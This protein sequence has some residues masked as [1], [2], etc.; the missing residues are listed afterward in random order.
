MLNVGAE[1]DQLRYASRMSAGRIII[2][3]TPTANL[4]A[5]S[6]AADPVHMWRSPGALPRTPPPARR[7]APLQRG[8]ELRE[9]DAERAAEVA[10]LDDVDAALAALT[11][12]D[13][14]PPKMMADMVASV[15]EPV[16][17]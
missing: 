16:R 2:P 9:R 5:H 10:H 1:H 12:R 11:L 7:A 17:S 6:K 4:A 3:A 15:N 13:E 14:A 8:H